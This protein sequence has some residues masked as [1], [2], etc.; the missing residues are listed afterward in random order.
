MIPGD[1]HPLEYFKHI[2]DER[3]RS[4]RTNRLIELDIHFV[5][6]KVERVPFST[7]LNKLRQNEAFY[8]AFK[9]LNLAHI[10]IREKYDNILSLTGELLDKINETNILVD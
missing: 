6:I 10:R 2:Q 9:G 5:P 8:S 7:G 3:L 4:R 1:H